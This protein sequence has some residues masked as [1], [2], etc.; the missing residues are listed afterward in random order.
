M[1]IIPV[2]FIDNEV[3]KR[4]DMQPYVT[5]ICDRILKICKENGI[6]N[7]R[8]VQMDCDWTKTT[9]PQY[10]TFLQ[11]IKT[12][13]HDKG[14]KLYATI[15]L[16]Q[17]SQTPPDVDKG[18]LMSYNTGAVRDEKTHNSILAA[19]D[20][21]LYAKHLSK[22]KL[23]LDVAYPAFSWSVVFRD[24]KLVCLL[25]GFDTQNQ[26]IKPDK[27]NIFS[28]TQ[29]FVTQ[30]QELKAGDKIRIET[31]EYQQI[32]KSKAIIEKQIKGCSVAIFALDSANLIKFNDNEIKKIF[33]H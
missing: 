32:I 14:L 5:Q 26:N 18:L 9:Q 8:Y 13:L 1:E 30:G 7:I 20:V 25:R 27:Q 29:D 23:E 19:S 2:I 28:V 33:N 12:L 22:Y 4:V 11:N 17:L 6:T 21:N 31:S 3:F 15:R 10:F 24:G 16:H